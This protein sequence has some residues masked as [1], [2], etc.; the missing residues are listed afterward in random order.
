[1]T[2]WARVHQHRQQTGAGDD[3]GVRGRG[4]HGDQ[5][6]EAD[7][8]DG[9]DVAR[10]EGHEVMDDCKGTVA[11]ARVPPEMKALGSW[12][13]GDDVVREEGHRVTDGGKGAVVG[14]RVSPKKKALGSRTDGDDI[15]REEGHGVMDSGEGAVA[16]A[17]VLPEKKAPGSQMDSDDVAREDGPQVIV[18]ARQGEGTMAG[19]RKGGAREEE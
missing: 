2:S 10:E 9:N 18:R 15:A 6:T 16:R 13:N 7:A 8:A 12:M 19:A 3:R 5:T 1:L 11:R 4:R 14:A 17:R